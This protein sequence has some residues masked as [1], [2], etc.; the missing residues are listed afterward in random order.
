MAQANNAP[1]DTLVR[2][3]VTAGE[4][5]LDIGVPLGTP[6]VELL[7]SFARYL[8]RLDAQTVHGGYQLL[9][10]DGSALDPSMTFAAQDVEHGE[11]LTL[12]AGVDQPQPKVYDD[13]VEAVG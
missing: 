3:T 10:A 2:V 9:R 6:V 7:P 4:R 5:R 12:T 1:G 8:G 13:L 11:V